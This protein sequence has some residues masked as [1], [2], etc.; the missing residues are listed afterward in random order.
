M[1]FLDDGNRLHV[2]GGCVTQGCILTIGTKYK[3]KEGTY[4][5]QCLEVV[6]QINKKR[7]MTLTKGQNR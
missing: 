1:S 7:L 6:Q 4:I 2:K 5:L 3:A